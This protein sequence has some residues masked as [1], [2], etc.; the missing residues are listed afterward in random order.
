LIRELSRGIAFAMLILAGAAIL[1]YAQHAGMIG[2]DAARQLAQIAIGLGLAAYANV[3]PKRIGRRRA[4]PRAEALS[5]TT[6][7][8]GGWSLT[9]AGLIY[10]MLWAFAPSAADTA[11]MLVIATAAVVTL[12]YALWAY[13]SCRASRDS[14]HLT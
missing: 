12:G 7:R 3:M 5:Q 1:R 6:L 4:S 10:A 11:G 14:R 8:V 9:L 2:G 13:A